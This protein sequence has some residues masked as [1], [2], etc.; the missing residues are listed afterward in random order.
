[1]QL[2]MRGP[3]DAVLAPVPQYPLYSAVT[4]LLNG[5]LAPYYLDEAAAWGVTEAELFNALERAEAQGAT[6]RALVVIN[7]GNPT[8]QSMPKEVLEQILAFCAKNGLVLMAD[9][10]YQENVYGSAPAFV[11][12]KQILMELKAKGEKGDAAAKATS[13]AA[14]KA[15]ARTHGNEREEL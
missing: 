13:E 8:G 11:S 2:L 15:A 6:A 3:H 12:F 5:T 4:T 9:E 14:A 7:P 1:M 10:V